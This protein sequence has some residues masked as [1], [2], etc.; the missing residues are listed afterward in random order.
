MVIHLEHKIFRLLS[1]VAQEMNLPCYVIGGYVRDLLLHRPSKDIDIV[2]VG[3]GIEMAR[4][5]ASKTGRKGRISIYRNF[6]T[7]MLRLPDMELEFVG[8]RTESYSPDSRKPV[9]ENGTLQDDQNRRDFTINT[10]AVSLNPD[11]YGL[12]VDPFGGL[13]DLRQGI[14]RTPQNPEVTFS[15]DP[16]RMMRA[17]RLA[18]QLGFTVEER[19][20]SAIR[21]NRERIRIVSMER[22]T[23]ELNKIIMCKRPSEG[24][25]LLDKTGLLPEVFPE[26]ARL[27]G[28][29][30]KDRQGHKDNFY[31]TLQV[32]DNIAQK[33]ENLWLRWAVLLHDIAKPATKKY[34]AG[35]GWTFY[36]HEFIGSKMVSEVF[37]R[38]H[39]PMGQNM[40]YVQ[41]LVRLHLRPISL[42]E[43]DVTDSAIRRLIFEAGEN[44]DDLMD[45][46]EADVTSRNDARVKLYLDNF[47]LVRQKIKEIEEKDAIRNFQPPITGEII[48]KTYNLGPCREIGIIKN[49]IKEAILEGVIGN[50][51]DEAHELML[52]EAEKLG[53]KA[54]AKN[55]P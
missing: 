46:C 41:K 50:N 22:I 28:I 24:L 42:V 3:S 44:I 35:H 30:K 14:I 15:D 29:D 47:M 12:L 21:S 20:L 13:D 17:V 53:L 19:S 7:A 11:S 8:A 34:V 52:R 4:A 38:L 43:E 26:L 23:D 9:V 54:D 55:V 6:G 49:A 45:L 48:M 39:L 10:L 36:G 37:R 32:L 51:Y 40:K 31:H 18:G 5:V 33:S 2:V 27:K 25:Q 1:G 16:L